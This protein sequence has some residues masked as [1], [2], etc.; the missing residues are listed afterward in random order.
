MVNECQVFLF[1]ALLYIV[2]LLITWF[3]FYLALLSIQRDSN[4]QFITQAF[5][6]DICLS[7]YITTQD[8]VNTVIILCHTPETQCHGLAGFKIDASVLLLP[9]S[10]SGFPWQ[11]CTK[12]TSQ[13]IGY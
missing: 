4:I 6:A 5:K 10:Y 12:I 11:G 9:M 8:D 13:K 2:H 7:R 3:I 1:V